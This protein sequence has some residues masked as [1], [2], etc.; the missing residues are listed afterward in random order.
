LTLAPGERLVVDAS[1]AVKWA[2]P[3]PDSDQA[4]AL[5]DHTLV[6]PDLF[7]AECANVLWKKLR[8][9]DLTEEEAGIA[10]RTLE[11]VD[12]VV[13]PSRAYLGRAV[14]IAAALEH[15]AY[16]AIYLAVAEAFGLRLATAD[17]RL[18]R[19]MRQP[20]GTFSHLVVAL[21]EVT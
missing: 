2:V 20:P 3:E 15:P 5:L 12:L 7:F 4:A 8:L 14:A 11:Q 10:A 9:G 1:V 17:A 16:D 13:V 19:K 18:I 6:A 21:S